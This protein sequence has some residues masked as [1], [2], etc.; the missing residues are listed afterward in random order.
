MADELVRV[1]S[2]LSMKGKRRGPAARLDRACCTRQHE[3]HDDDK[4]ERI[5]EH[6]HRQARVSNKET[7]ILIQ[8]LLLS[9]DTAEPILDSKYNEIGERMLIQRYTNSMTTTTAQKKKRPPPGVT[10]L[11]P[12]PVR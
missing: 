5:S 4:A 1:H 12:S 6:K 7:K 3:S 9:D 11:Q 8:K 2:K 10:H